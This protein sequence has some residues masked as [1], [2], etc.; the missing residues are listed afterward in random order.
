MSHSLP[1]KGKQTKSLTIISAFGDMRYIH[2][3]TL[4]TVKSHSSIFT[5]RRDL[6]LQAEL[7][8]TLGTET[9]LARAVIWGYTKI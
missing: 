4:L 3:A 1:R 2:K 9:L 8:S 7:Y 6:S 5:L